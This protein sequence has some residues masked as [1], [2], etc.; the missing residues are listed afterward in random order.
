MG[1]AFAKPFVFFFFCRL[2]NQVNAI[3][4]CALCVF[5]GQ[6]PVLGSLIHQSQVVY[7]NC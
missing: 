5:C 1:A 2:Q 3:D 7:V 4:G 6:A